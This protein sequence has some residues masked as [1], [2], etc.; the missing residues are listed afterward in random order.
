MSKKSHELGKWEQQQIVAWDGEGAN[1]ETGEHIYNLLANSFGH[2]IVNHNGLSTEEC[3]QFL[4][5]TSK[6]GAINVVFGGSYDVNMMLRDITEDRIRQLWNN[7][8]TYWKNYTLHYANRKRFSVHEWAPGKRSPIRS[9]TL[10]DV[11]GFFQTSFVKAAKKWLGEDFVGG[12]DIFKLIEETKVKRNTFR[13]TQIDDIL[14]Y[15]YAECQLLVIMMK[16]L[17]QALSEAG[18]RL[19]RFDGAGAIASAILSQWN[20]TSHMGDIPDWVVEWSQYAYSGGR[21]EAPMVG[22][23]DP[24][25]GQHVYRYDIN[26]AYPFAALSLPSYAG[27]NWSLDKQWNGKP[28]SIVEVE[29]SYSTDRPFYPLWYRLPNGSILYPKRGRGRYYG[30]E[31][32][33]LLDNYE[34]GKDFEIIQSCNCELA[35]TDARPF[36]FLEDIY[37]QRRKFKDEG[38]MAHEAIK[39]G[40]NSIYGKLAQQAGYRHGRIPTYHHLL[41]AGHITAS[42]R[43]AL[44]SHAIQCPS[45]IVAFATD[46]IISLHPIIC[47][48]GTG[49]GQWTPEEFLG[50]TLVQ[51]GVYWLYDEQEGWSEKYRGFDV[52]S[53]TRE[54]IIDSWANNREYEARL[55]RFYGMGSAVG[56]NNFQEYWRVWRTEPRN[57]NLI[58][59]TK[60]VPLPRHKK[61]ASKLEMT[62]PAEN[63][64]GTILSTPYPLA[65]GLLAGVTLRSAEFTEDVRLMEQ[66][67]ADSYT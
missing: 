17:F 21:I 30:V 27:A 34:E 61:Y 32:A 36:S 43:R 11:I 63:H 33:S 49:L 66:E 46:A 65:W 57:L 62:L 59:N 16:S 13:I 38:S 22:N 56:M 60:R 3:L 53:L 10:W 28:Y 26:S 39:L 24:K 12:L 55:T 41:W 48:T 23:L 44:Y 25:D 37:K 14:K 9:M 15:N 52:G 47:D 58:P 2:Y 50:I 4:L 18:I 35:V 42:T 6:E 1:L 40:M 8:K 64:H 31:L 54:A 20:I 7:G 5:R 51:A 19:K 67:L 45:D 29:W